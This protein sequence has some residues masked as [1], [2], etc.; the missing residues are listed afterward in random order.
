MSDPALAPRG[1]PGTLKGRT[2]RWARAA[3]HWLS[4]I[5]VLVAVAE[6]TMRIDDAVTWGASLLGPYSE[7]HVMIRDSLGVRG[8]PNFRYEK[9][10]MNNQGFRGPDL[11]LAPTPGTRRVIVLGS[12]ET[13]GL[14]EPAGLEYP[15]RMQQVLDSI[16]PGRFEVVNAALPG[17][18]LPA[19]AQY[20]QR[21]V[22]RLQPAVVLVYPNPS[23]YLDVN[24]LPS[25]P[26]TLPTR[27]TA[28]RKIDPELLRPRLLAKSREAVKALIPWTLVT[29]FREWRLRGIRRAHPPEWFWES[30]PADRMALFGEHLDRLVGA[31]QATGATVM[32]ATHTNR[33]VGASAA[34]VARDRRHLVDPMFKYYP[35][36]SAQVLIAV[37]SAAN[38]V[39]RE[40]GRQRQV[41]VVEVFG[42]IPPGAE[43]FGDY[44]HFTDRG[45]D[46]LARILSD[47]LLG[48]PAGAHAAWATPVESPS[49]RPTARS[50]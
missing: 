28:G 42:R 9:W 2:G 36:A 27:P 49:S 35:R 5:V 45:S 34:D 15:A 43:Y 24:P 20:Y 7:D 12:S 48:L 47:A 3:L 23:F 1:E 40:I 10:R 30:V 39:V 19:M 17:M 44:V 21:V 8:R 38:S 46:I 25:L 22:A 31:V 11:R 50:R 6:T 41:K 32:L 4:I 37:D 26:G 14:F 33:F 13:F 16:A 29:R 18:G